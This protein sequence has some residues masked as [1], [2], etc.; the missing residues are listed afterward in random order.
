M[1]WWRAV[2]S[3]QAA[4]ASHFGRRPCCR[5]SP[6]EPPPAARP[7]TPRGPAPR[8]TP[9]PRG[10]APEGLRTRGTP[11]P[12]GPASR[13]TPTCKDSA[14]ARSPLA[15]TPA[16]TMTPAPRNDPRTTMTPAPHDDSRNREPARPYLPHAPPVT[17]TPPEPLVQAAALDQDSLA[18]SRR[19]PG[20]R[21]V[22]ADS[23][24]GRSGPAPVAN[25]PA[26]PGALITTDN[27]A[28]LAILR[29]TLQSHDKPSRQ[30]VFCESRKLISI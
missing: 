26:C 8:G 13:G 3:G 20:R 14:P 16:P 21:D 7:R 29:L 10:P 4:P 18:A 22:R 9:Y 5:T 28:C 24:A 30:N 1:P 27:A 15:M 12:R 25:F 11:R 2:D 19:R 17:L 6:G 23:A